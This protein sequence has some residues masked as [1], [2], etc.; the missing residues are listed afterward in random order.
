MILLQIKVLQDS[1]VCESKKKNRKW[2]W[3]LGRESSVS[4]DL[5]PPWLT[6]NFLFQDAVISSSPAV[7]TVSAAEVAV[8]APVIRSKT[9]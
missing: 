2:E 8:P 9:K 6:G 3:D 5:T 4:G 1:S 7:A